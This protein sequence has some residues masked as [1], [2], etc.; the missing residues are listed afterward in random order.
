VYFCSQIPSPTG[1]AVGKYG[2][3]VMA[4]KTSVDLLMAKDEEQLSPLEK[5]LLE[6]QHIRLGTAW[7]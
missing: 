7:N 2:T 4:D 5:Q 1:S 3:V 6:A